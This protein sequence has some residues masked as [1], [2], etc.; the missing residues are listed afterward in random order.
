MGVE[1]ARIALRGCRRRS[2]PQVLV[3]ATTAPAYLDKTNATAIHAALGLP[4][5]TPALRR[6]RLG[7]LG[8]DRRV[9]CGAAVAGAAARRADATSA[10][11]CPAAP[12]SATAATPRPRSCFRSTA[13]R[14]ARRAPRRRRRRPRSSSTAGALPGDA[15]FARVGGALRRARLRAAG[16]EAITDALKPAGL[17]AERRRPRD[18]RPAL[19]GRAVSAVA[20]VGRRA[21]RGVVDDLTSRRSA[22][23]A[24]RTRG[25]CSPTCST[26]PSR[27]RSIA[28]RRRSPTAPTSCV[29]RTTDALAAYRERRRPTV[30]EQIAAGRDDLGY[31][32]VPHLARLPAARAA[33]PARARR[34]RPP[35]P[36]LRTEAWKFGFVGIACTTCGTR[37][38]AAGA[39]VHATAAPSTR[40]TPGAHGRRAG[41]DR[42]L[43]HRPARLLAAARRSCSRSSTSTAAA[44]SSASSPTSTPTTVADRR[45]GRDDVPPALHRRR[46][47]QLLLEGTARSA[48]ATRRR[49]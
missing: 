31:A 9:A 17:D 1:A 13:T 8:V 14:R 7:A 37:P 25:C 44:A 23:P 49:Q 40:W 45:P 3:F 30:A 21:A 19:H 46:H 20:E 24:P 27:A 29:L 22:T 26:A 12:T 18:R 6:R 32:D 35:R 34:A 16:R 36:S 5:A 48:Q 39:G 11:A 43:H 38:P 10:P 47:P 41:H 28:R 15:R 42:H 2:R 4:V 33:A